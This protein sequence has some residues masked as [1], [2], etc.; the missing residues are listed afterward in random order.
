MSEA[1]ELAT[2]IAIELITKA[3]EKNKTGEQKEAEVC[4]ILSRLDNNIIG[5]GFIPDELEAQLIDFGIDKVQEHL[6]KIDLKDF[7]KTQYNRIK[8]LLKRLFNR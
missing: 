1:K 2:K 6:D 4:K 8:S 5:L 3:S 7:V